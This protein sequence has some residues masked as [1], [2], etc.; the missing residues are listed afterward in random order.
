MNDLEGRVTDSGQVVTHQTIPFSKIRGGWVQDNQNCWVRLI[1][2][3]GE[4]QVVRS[5]HSSKKIATKE[6]VLRTAHQCIDKINDAY[7]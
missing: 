2:P 3:T 5:G 4:D 1:V 7:E 6:A